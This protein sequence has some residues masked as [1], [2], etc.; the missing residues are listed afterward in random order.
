MEAVVFSIDD[1]EECNRLASVAVGYADGHRADR[2]ALAAILCDG[3]FRPGQ[4][5]DLIDRQN[6]F[7]MSQLTDLIDNVAASA[8]ISPMA[9]T[10]DGFWADHFTYHMDLIESYQT[11]YPDRIEKLLYDEESCLT[12]FHLGL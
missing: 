7:L 1:K 5:A 6:I 12:T 4:L 10:R 8:T 3:S 2:E 11:I 9:V